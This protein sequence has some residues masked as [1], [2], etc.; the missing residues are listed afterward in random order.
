MTSADLQQLIRRL[1]DLLQAQADDENLL[2]GKWKVAS[3]FRPRLPELFALLW[4][5]PREAPGNLTDADL[6]SLYRLQGTLLLY[7]AALVGWDERTLCSVLGPA[8]DGSTA[9]SFVR[10]LRGRPRTNVPLPRLIGLA[11]LRNLEAAA[12]RALG[13][14]PVSGSDWAR[15]FWRSV[16]LEAPPRDADSP[17]GIVELM[18]PKELQ[19]EVAVGILAHPAR[20]N[21]PAR[22]S[23]AEALRKGAARLRWLFNAGLKRLKELVSDP[24]R[25]LDLRKLNQ[26]LLNRYDGQTFLPSDGE[27]TGSL[28]PI[29]EMADTPT[30]R[31]LSECVDVP[32]LENP[33]NVGIADWRIVLYPLAEYLGKSEFRIHLYRDST[34][35]FAQVL[36]DNEADLVIHVARNADERR[37][38]LLETLFTFGH[39]HLFCKARRIEEVL[40]ELNPA[41]KEAMWVEALLYPEA[42][43]CLS[44]EERNHAVK[45]VLRKSRSIVEL[46]SDL[47]GC[48]SHLNEILEED[49]GINFDMSL[50]S[51]DAFRKWLADPRYDVFIG[52]IRHY[53][54]LRLLRHL[55]V[56]DPG[57]DCDASQTVPPTA[58]P[59]AVAADSA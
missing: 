3:G 11:E 31:K 47:A 52:G 25:I 24:E 39:Y 18:G 17:Y 23:E 1:F 7:V 51:D 45:L 22:A 30:N 6:E 16:G 28:L 44:D 2:E 57:A 26:K 48:F 56:L 55:R 43:A 4:D 41:A 37:F 34:Q 29:L 36:R 58:P 35:R 27:V 14:S 33:L 49:L 38:T 59:V 21:D 12:G 8:Y 5:L 53:E 42:A 54:H 10:P 9:L 13:T 32:P 40:T 15:R 50:G 20:I 19:Y 46:G